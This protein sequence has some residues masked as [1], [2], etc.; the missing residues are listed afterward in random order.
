[1]K[2]IIDECGFHIELSVAGKPPP[3]DE[4]FT[5]DVEAKRVL[6][7]YVGVPIQDA[8]KTFPRFWHGM[9]WFPSLQRA[10]NTAKIARVGLEPT[11]PGL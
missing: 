3:A 9:A 8:L 2:A 11:T 10:E 1:M 6:A 4:F 5:R 7:H